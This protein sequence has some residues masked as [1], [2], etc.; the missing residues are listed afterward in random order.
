KFDR[1]ASMIVAAAR[2][3]Q[4]NGF[5]I[6]SM[7]LVYA[8]TD[9]MAWSFREHEGENNGD[10]FKAWV[11]QFWITQPSEITS[12]DLWVAR[13]ALLHEQGSNSRLTRTGKATALFYLEN[14]GGG[15]A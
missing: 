14:D 4:Q 12:T 10:D 5:I 3:C 8:A 13:N 2:L 9:G 6:P 15:N 11:D 7:M 1:H